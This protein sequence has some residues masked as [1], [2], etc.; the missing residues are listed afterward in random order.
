VCLDVAKAIKERMTEIVPDGY[1]LAE[2]CHDAAQDLDGHGWH[3]TMD[4]N[5][6]TRPVWAWVTSNNAEPR[7]MSGTPGPT[8][9]LDALAIITTMREQHARAPWRSWA[10]SFTLLGSHDTARIA[11][12]CTP[13]EHLVAAGLLF[14]LP[15]VPMIFAGDEIGVEGNNNNLTRQPFPWNGQTWNHTLFDAYRQLISLRQSC[16]ALQHGSLRWVYTQGDA[17][18]F[19]RET[20]KQR[21]L[22]HVARAAHLPIDTH[23]LIGGMNDSTETHT[24]CATG[25]AVR[26]WDITQTPT[27]LYPVGLGE[28]VLDE[29]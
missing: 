29:Q 23:T 2:H 17:I 26:I 8:P 7:E 14:T 13:D 15:G 18:V 4:Y 22:I 3:G 1:L 12:M 19:L 6:F 11:S 5:G 27:S 16:E 21:L 10:A 9:R 20:A 28:S 25:P 24:L